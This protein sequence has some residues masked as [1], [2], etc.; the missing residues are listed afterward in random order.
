M[1]IKINKQIIEIDGKDFEA[2]AEINLK[3]IIKE[4]KED[5]F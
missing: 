5:L 3:E 4:E 1:K 2:N